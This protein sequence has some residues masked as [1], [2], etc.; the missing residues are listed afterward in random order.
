MLPAARVEG[1]YAI[2]AVCL[3]NICRSPIAVVVLRA[4]LDE[5]GLDGVEVISAGTGGWHAGDPMDRRSAAILRE[6]DYDPTHHRAQQ[7]DPTWHER[8]D[9]VLA[10]DEQ[11]LADLGGPSER[12]ML[13]RDL[14]P[15]GRG[16][17]PDPY[18]GGA[19]GF[20]RVLAMIERT[21][22]VIVAQLTSRA[23]AP[24]AVRL[25]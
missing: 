1:R 17:V 4:R 25:S 12:V 23:R 11:N 5:A 10:M 22:E 18:Y 13:W 16:E 24:Q 14:D 15:E 2:A 20:A 21:A 9:L 3:G 7:W 19:D 6:H 8:Y